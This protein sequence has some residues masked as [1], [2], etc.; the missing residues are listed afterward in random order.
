[1]EFFFDFFVF[2]ARSEETLRFME[3]CPRGKM[4]GCECGDGKFVNVPFDFRTL[5]SQCRPTK[6]SELS[7]GTKFPL[8]VQ[9]DMRSNLGWS[10]MSQFLGCFLANQLQ[11]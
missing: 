11:Y 8:P 9:E 3:L 1:M 2:P 5:Y 6:V 7:S 4:E 10:H